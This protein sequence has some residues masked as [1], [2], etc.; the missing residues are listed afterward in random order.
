VTGVLFS[1]NCS[2]TIG[3]VTRL[4]AGQKRNRSSIPDRGKLF[5]SL[6]SV[7]TG[8]GTDNILFGKDFC[9]LHEGRGEE[10][11]WAWN[12]PLISV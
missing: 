8:C 10:A 11:A 12:W 5:F 3:I 4:Q 1:V 9:L 7:E 2:E 6:L